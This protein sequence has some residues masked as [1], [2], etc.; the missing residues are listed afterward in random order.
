MPSRPSRRALRVATA[1][2]VL[3]SS[4][5]VVA[6]PVN[7]AQDTT[8]NVGT[9]DW[10][11]DGNW[12]NG[13]PRNIDTAFFTNTGTAT[14]DGT[15]VASKLVVTGTATLR[16]GSL[17]LGDNLQVYDVARLNLTASDLLGSASIT[18]NKS[19]M[20]VGGN[21]NWMILDSSGNASATFTVTTGD[22]N[23]GYVGNGNFLGTNIP[24]DVNNPVVKPAT[25]T[26]K[27]SISAQAIKISS[28]PAAGATDYNW[29]GTYGQGDTLSATTLVVG[30][31]GD[32]GGAENYGGSWTVGATAI[33][34]NATSSGN[35]VTIADGGSFTTTGA[36]T[37]G[38]SGS[39][40]TVYLGDHTAGSLDLGSSSQNL[41]IGQNAGANG[42]S[43]SMDAAS[44]LLVQKAIIVGDS[45]STNTLVIH[46][47]GTV[48]SD[49][50][51]I[52]VQSSS[53]GNAVT[54]D[55]SVWSLTGGSVRVGVNG[56]GNTFEIVNGGG[57]TMSTADKDFTVGYSRN[58][59]SNNNTLRVDG[60]GSKLLMTGPNT[61]LWVSG[62]QGVGGGTGNKVIVTNGGELDVQAV[63]VTTGGLLAGDSTVKGDVTVA[64]NGVI[65]P[66][67]GTDGTLGT[68]AIVGNLSLAAF[69]SVG[70]LDIDVVSGVA[71]VVTV[72][73]ALDITGATLHTDF[74]GA[75]SFTPLVIATYG[76]LTGTFAV[77]QGL[78]PGWSIDYHYQSLNQI[79]LVPEPSTLVLAG[80]GMA[81][82]LARRWRRRQG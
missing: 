27:A 10:S 59:A 46:N 17:D 25:G 73:G 81:G 76:T 77:V 57:V 31:A 22:L 13:V 32:Q 34:N 67:D 68:L 38:V 5:P 12:T 52:G 14:L 35:Y 56:S 8:W 43:L 63:A 3:C 53:T 72:T 26:G 36:F 80:I 42:N 65:A 64:G 50:A 24:A 37:V 60:T 4:S 62:V 44:S 78:P 48:V 58:S 15:P 74:S 79:A 40:N 23:V 69:G 16:N 49:S 2:L 11:T 75:A 30:D 28:D 70:V 47:G 71:D 39:G 55:G 45:G 66:G 1:A 61:A 41:I 7:P 82:L 51:D 6:G 21:N 19:D 54:V 18:T 29:L 20:G 9:G 33:G